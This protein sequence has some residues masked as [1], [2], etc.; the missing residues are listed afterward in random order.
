MAAVIIPATFTALITGLEFWEDKK[1]LTEQQL[2]DRDNA[3]NLVLEAAIL[4]KGYLYNRRELNALQDRDKE[5]E[6][7]QAWQK[8]ANSIY[9]FDE[10]LFQSAQIKALAWADPR[11]W[12]KAEQQNIEV[13]LDTL[14][15]QCQ[16]LKQN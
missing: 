1:V 10:R 3:V 9:R 2:K 5:Q 7:S 16:W 15:Q 6:I 11:E 12:L 8:A 13:K 4:T 14:I